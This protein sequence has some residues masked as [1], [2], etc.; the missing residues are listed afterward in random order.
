MKEAGLNETFPQA[1]LLRLEQA[2]R[3]T[4]H[5]AAETPEQAKLGVF[6]TL[7]IWHLNELMRHQNSHSHY[8]QL[9]PIEIII[10]IF[11]LKLLPSVVVKYEY[12]PTSK[13]FI[14]KIL[15]EPLYR[16]LSYIQAKYYY[17]RRIFHKRRTF[18][19]NII[20]S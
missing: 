4:A 12:K 11:F 9:P 10:G 16:G 6:R 2:E 13:S 20:L 5:G 14:S 15:V 7:N 1:E 3:E 8:F 17:D 19:K 18:G